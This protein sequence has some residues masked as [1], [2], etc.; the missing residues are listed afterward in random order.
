MHWRLLLGAICLCSL[1]AQAD[2]AK[3]GIF[4]DDFSYADTGALLSHGW[5]ARVARGHPGVPGAEWSPAA[6]SLVDDV[7]QAGNRVLRLTARTD[8]TPEGTQQAQVCHARKYLEG[9]YAARIRFTDDPVSGADGDPVI[10]TFYAVAPLRHDFD[11]QFS[12][13]D[14]EYL[15]NGGWGAPETRLYGIS[16][17][18][19]QIEPWHAYNQLHQEFGS[20]AGWHVLMMQIANGRTRLFVDGRQIDEHGGRNYPAVPMAISFSLWF[21]PGGLLP[22]SALPRVWEQDV[23]WV[24]HAKDRVMS[25]DEVLAAVAD[26]RRRGSARLDTVPEGEPPLASGCDF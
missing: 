7:A 10:E 23:D 8:G 24:F 14:W 12:E 21:S 19:V 2:D 6:V 1:A 5:R 9:T 3:G 22:A 25:P 4:F 20:H 17:Q 11:P 26:L 13:F 15:P 16:W 18:T